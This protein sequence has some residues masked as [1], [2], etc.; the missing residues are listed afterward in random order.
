MKKR[1]G[2]ETVIYKTANLKVTKF[3]TEDGRRYKIV[4]KRGA[5][6]REQLGAFISDE[7]ALD[8]A[9]SELRYISKK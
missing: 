7:A 4:I 6:S 1:K 8:Y 3:M 5:Q 9:R 2:R